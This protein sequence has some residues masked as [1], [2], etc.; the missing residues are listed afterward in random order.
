MFKPSY[1]TCI[2]CDRERLIVVKS[3]YC[4]SCNDKQKKDKKFALGKLF[5]PLE[6][7]Q[8]SRREKLKRGKAILKKFK[9]TGER[10]VHYQ[11]WEKKRHQCE[12]CGVWLGDYPSPT[13]FAHK[14]RKSKRPDL[15]LDPN[16]Y[17][18]YCFQCHFEFDQGTKESFE[19]RKRTH[20]NNNEQEG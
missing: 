16:N 18:L 4:A 2:A 17:F 12:H 19:K 10:K 8:K 1:A 3:G 11:L 15:R 9:V 7:C 6:K 14:I 20:D 5:S 13:F